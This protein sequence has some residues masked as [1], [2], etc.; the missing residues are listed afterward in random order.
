MPTLPLSRTACSAVAPETGTAA[1]ASKPRRPAS[2]PT[3]RLRRPLA[4]RTS[5][6]PCPSLR[7]GSK[8]L[9]RRADV[10]DGAG[11]VPASCSDLRSTEAHLSTCLVRAS[12]HDVPH[13]RPAACARTRPCT[14]FS[15]ATGPLRL[16]LDPVGVAVSVLNDDFAVVLLGSVRCPSPTQFASCSRRQEDVATG[17]SPRSSTKWLTMVR[18]SGYVVFNHSVEQGD[19]RWPTTSSPE[20][21]PR[22]PI[23]RGATS[24]PDS[25][26]ATRRSESSPSPTTSP[27]RRCPS[28][29]RC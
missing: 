25:R 15:P 8:A 21:L 12:R 7:P 26:W 27:S 11:D 4:R 9:D 1:A 20:S 3:C 10:L 23:R 17:A 2:G 19:R 24:R 14:S 22:S 28:T 5:P 18:S 13:V 29:S 6:R 16:E